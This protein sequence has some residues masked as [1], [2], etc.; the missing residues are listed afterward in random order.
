MSWINKNI[1]LVFLSIV[2][3][4]TIIELISRELGFQI[5]NTKPNQLYV[6]DSRYGWKYASGEYL[7]T[8]PD[9]TNVRV[10]I[11]SDGFREGSQKPLDDS[12]KVLFIGDSVTAGIQVNDHETFS[13][14]V[15]TTSNGKYTSYNYGVNGYSTDQSYLVLE[16]FLKN[17]IPD[18]VVYTFVMNDPEFNLKD[19]L[20]HNGSHWGKPYFDSELKYHRK[21]FSKK[22]D[23][24]P[25][26]DN[27]ITKVKNFLRSNFA[28]YNM[29]SR[30][31]NSNLIKGEEF[32][33][34]NLINVEEC[35][36][37]DRYMK[38]DSVLWKERWKRTEKLI[39]LINQEVKSVGA[40]LII[41][42]HIEAVSAEKKLRNRLEACNN[43]KESQKM[44]PDFP[45]DMIAYIANKNNIPIVQ[46]SYAENEEFSQKNNC[47]INFLSSNRA[48]V[49]DGHL[50][51]CGHRLLSEKLVNT[52]DSLK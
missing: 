45:R 18:Y 50:T 38:F 47:T 28:T 12:K 51:K 29:L 34:S 36:Y 10:T 43:G 2:F 4:I 41:A 33:N 49:I 17:E 21:P 16:D 19:S 13:D 20:S 11:A 1:L 52:L 14:L 40:R 37:N 3:S 7:V 5:L 25:S 15:Q 9:K 6:D 8:S 30:F 32:K 42:D 23:F 24:S 22:I 31:K 26:E 27:S 35:S 39:Q 48:R 46:T 44:S